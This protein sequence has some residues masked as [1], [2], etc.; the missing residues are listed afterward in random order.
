MRDIN[1]NRF[2]KM[3]KMHKI[4][5]DYFGYYDIGSGVLVYARNGGN[6]RRQQLSYLVQQQHKQTLKVKPC[7]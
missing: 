6:K 4:K 1:E 7:N 2:N 5:P 3:L